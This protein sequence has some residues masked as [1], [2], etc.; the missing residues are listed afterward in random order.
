[1]VTFSGC[2]L[3][4]GDADHGGG[5]VSLCSKDVIFAISH[6]AGGGSGRL[7]RNLG[8]V[9]E[10]GVRGGHGIF[11]RPDRSSGDDIAKPGS[12]GL[13][14]SWWPGSTFFV[15]VYVLEEP[16]LGRESLW[17]RNRLGDFVVP[18][19]GW[20]E[21]TGVRCREDSRVISAAHVC[22]VSG[23]GVSAV[24]TY[25]QGR[26]RWNMGGGPEKN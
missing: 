4:A 21:E 8:S 23:G 9:R 25:Y 22:A 10:G 16:S 12:P 14:C 24:C 7:G 1:M 13:G 17:S 5:L 6:V 2:G 26:G 19:S 3:G 20:A 15:L 11:S 18:C